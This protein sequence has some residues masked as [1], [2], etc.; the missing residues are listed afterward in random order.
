MSPRQL[1]AYTE[2]AKRDEAE[3]EAR[4]FVLLRSSNPGNKNFKKQLKKLTEAGD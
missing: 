3:R 1:H 2:L 4:L